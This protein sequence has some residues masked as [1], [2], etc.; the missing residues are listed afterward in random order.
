MNI[1]TCPINFATLSREE[2]LKLDYQVMRH[3]FA[4]HNSLGRFCDEKIYQADLK[5]RLARGELG[6]VTTEVPV[7]IRWKDFSK[8]YYLDLVEQEAAVYELKASAAIA[9]EHKAQLLNYLLILGLSVGKLLNFGAPSLQWHFA[10]TRLTPERRRAIETDASHWR[11]LSEAC[12]RFRLAVEDLLA[13]WGAFL[14]VAL[15]EEALVWFLGGEQKVV[16]RLPLSRDGV[17][18]GAQNCNLL[19]P[20]I[21]F[22][23][24]AHTTEQDRVE[25][26][27]RRFLDLTPLRA[28]QW[29]N[30]NH[31][32]IEFR[33]LTKQHG[34]KD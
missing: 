21:A 2:F 31:N 29:I 23:L 25:V 34:Q 12:G 22:H 15:Y 5:E 1:V 28:I 30:L 10:S 32:R 24:T 7:T 3:A 18:L 19:T 9:G 13:T 16:Q 11:E 26:H 33:T 20:D 8:T 14:D 27:L 4:T 17:L 6:P